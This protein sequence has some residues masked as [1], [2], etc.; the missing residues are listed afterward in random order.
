MK[1]P[2]AI[3]VLSLLCSNLQAQA[4]SKDSMR[5][6]TVIDNKSINLY[7]STGF[8]KSYF[9]EVGLGYSHFQGNNRGNM[10]NY[11][12]YSTFEHTVRNRKNHQVN[13]V[14]T[15]VY[16]AA[17]SGGYAVEAKYLWYP[18][19]Q[20]WII[21]PKIG[22]VIGGM[23]LLNYGYNISLNDQTFQQIGSHQFSLSL[24]VSALF[25]KSLKNK[26]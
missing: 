22:I 14:K 26:V 4:N 5:V 21:T 20:D 23:I 18:K 8:Q 3:F 13:G 7:A 24:N 11:G 15:G 2:L 9:Y 17:L 25:I 16:F 19:Q 6:K 12:I 1:T 10:V